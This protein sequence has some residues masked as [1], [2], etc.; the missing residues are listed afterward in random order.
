[1]EFAYRYDAATGETRIALASPALP[2]FLRSSLSGRPVYKLLFFELERGIN[3]KVP[4][5]IWERT[6]FRPEV[7]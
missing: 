7:E 6:I 4:K 2:G 3:R 5:F 1:M